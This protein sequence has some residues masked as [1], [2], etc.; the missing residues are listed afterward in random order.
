MKKILIVTLCLMA[1]VAK[2]QVTATSN[3][4]KKFANSIM[5]S[6]TDFF[7]STFQA[8]YERRLCPG[9]GLFI[10]AAVSYRNNNGQRTEGY[11][12]EIRFKYYVYSA[13]KEKSAQSIC[14]APYFQYKYTEQI[15][16]YYIM[17]YDM[18]PPVYYYPVK[19]YY[20]SFAGGVL[21][22]VNFVVAKKIVI[23]A[24]LGGGIKRTY[25][26][27]MKDYSNYAYYNNS[28]W[29]AG[30]NGIAPK[31]GIDVGFRF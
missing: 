3:T 22:G 31:A 1:T 13:E 17:E 5:F 11:K 8:G 9:S 27:H 4:D 7:N 18:Y 25:G 29:D 20:N 24:Y 15:P 12:G 30:Y 19:S 23:D 26:A 2:T 16:D 6:V 14:F 28:I 10:D 21:F